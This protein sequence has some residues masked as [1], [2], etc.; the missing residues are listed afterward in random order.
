MRYR[1]PHFPTHL[2]YSFAQLAITCGDDVTRW[3]SRDSRRRRCPG[4]CTE[5]VQI[6]NH[7]RR[8]RATSVKERIEDKGRGHD[9]PVVQCDIDGL[10]F[11]VLPSLHNPI[12]NTCLT[13]TSVRGRVGGVNVTARSCVIT[14]IL[15]TDSPSSQSRFCSGD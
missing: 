14:Y 13:G 11:R 12:C 2:A 4:V 7:G 5:G 15:R 9:T 3:T 8:C 6:V 10:T 1:W